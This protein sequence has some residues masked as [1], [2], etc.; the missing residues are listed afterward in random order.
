MALPGK[1]AGNC[2]YRVF[3]FL[4]GMGVRVSIAG[5]A[6]RVDIE[7]ASSPRC[8][9]PVCFSYFALSM[10]RGMRVSQ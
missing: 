1:E 5:G 7:R 9:F 4:D 8:S 10:K 3:G 6:V 2:E